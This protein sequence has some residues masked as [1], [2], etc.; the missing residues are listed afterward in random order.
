MARAADAPR[1]FTGDD[2]ISQAKEYV[3]VKKNI[4]QYEERQKELKA[5]LFLQIDEQGF[6]DDKGNIWLEL[7]EA[8]DDYLSL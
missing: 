7:P 6:E 5:A 8:V 3:A 2:L 1:E 4:D